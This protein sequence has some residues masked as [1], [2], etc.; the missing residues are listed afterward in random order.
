[1]LL[2]RIVPAGT[3]WENTVTFHHHE[4]ATKIQASFS[5]FLTDLQLETKIIQLFLCDISQDFTV[6]FTYS[7]L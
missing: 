5:P 4:N 1:M 2:G 6:V 7:I 3:N